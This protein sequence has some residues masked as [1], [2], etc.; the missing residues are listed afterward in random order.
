MA[1]PNNPQTRRR[2]L[3]QGGALETRKRLHEALATYIRERGG[4]LESVSGAPVMRFTA[5]LDSSLPADLQARG[6]LVTP[7]GMTMRI[8][9]V[10]GVELVAQTSSGHETVISGSTRPTLRRHHVAIE[11]VN[12]Y[13]LSLPPGARPA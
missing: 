11:Q 4:A 1:T 2:D 5:P 8:N 7:M 3:D 13:E 12:V 10:G 6:Y 9:P